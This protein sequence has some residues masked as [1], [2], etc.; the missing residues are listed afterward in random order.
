M[1]VQRYQVSGIIYAFSRIRELENLLLTSK[2]SKDSYMFYF[3]HESHG[4]NESLFP[5]KNERMTSPY[6]RGQIMSLRW[7]MFDG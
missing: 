2:N 5:V 1:L 4:L 3:E 6:D 7:L